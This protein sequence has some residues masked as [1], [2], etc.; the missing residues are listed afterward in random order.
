MASLVNVK[1]SLA[2]MNTAIAK[3]KE[4]VAPWITARY[5]EAKP[6]VLKFYAKSKSQL[7]GAF[8]SEHQ[9]AN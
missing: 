1:K 6:V 3:A 5:V 4:I 2:D 7:V 9:K 8:A